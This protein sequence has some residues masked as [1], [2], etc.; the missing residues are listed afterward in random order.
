MNH[1]IQLVA[2]RGGSHLAPEN[3]LAAFRNALT[4][5][6]DAIELARKAGFNSII[7]HRSGETEDTF[8]ADLAVAT[9]AGQVKTGSASRTDRVANGH[10]T[11]VEALRQFGFRAEPLAGLEP[12]GVKAIQ[13][14]GRH[15]LRRTTRASAAIPLHG[16]PLALTLASTNQP[17][18]F[19]ADSDDVAQT[20]AASLRFAAISSGERGEPS[21]CMPIASWYARAISSG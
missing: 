6:I 16:V 8:I 15:I 2:H 13:D 20:A 17:G 10:P 4:L 1:H 14:L 5:P 12:V 21:G 3:T 7:S 19:T 11:D 9:A 18:L